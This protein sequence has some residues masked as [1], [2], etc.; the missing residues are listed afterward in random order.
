MKIFENQLIFKEP[1]IR[2][3]IFNPQFTKIVTVIFRVFET[4][5]AK[6]YLYVIIN[7]ANYD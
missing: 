4:N 2:L 3:S 1:A 7:N 6:I 5:D